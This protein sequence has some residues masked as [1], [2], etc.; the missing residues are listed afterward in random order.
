MK[1]RLDVERVADDGHALGQPAAAVKRVEV[2]D[3]EYGVQEVASLLGPLC[4]LL[5]VEAG[6]SLSA[7]LLDEQRERRGRHE[8][9]DDIDAYL[10]AWVLLSKALE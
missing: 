3:H 1:Q 8:R 4:E 7:R 5:G 9:V 2:V 6:V 10:L